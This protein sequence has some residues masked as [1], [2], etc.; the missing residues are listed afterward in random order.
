[1]FHEIM[2]FVTTSLKNGER[3]IDVARRKGHMEVAQ[4]LLQSGAQ[5]CICITHKKNINT[6]TYY[7]PSFVCLC[8]QLC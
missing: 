4:L 2:C 3:A 8:Q 1:M 5:V 6:W 7:L